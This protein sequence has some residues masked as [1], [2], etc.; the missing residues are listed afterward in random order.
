M[1]QKAATIPHTKLIIKIRLRTDGA[2]RESKEAFLQSGD[3]FEKNHHGGGK[4]EENAAQEVL[5]LEQRQ[6]EEK[7]PGSPHTRRGY[8]QAKVICGARLMPITLA[9]PSR[10]NSQM[11]KVVASEPTMPPVQ[12]ALIFLKNMVNPFGRWELA[13]A[14]AARSCRCDSVVVAVEVYHLLP[15]G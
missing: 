7:S 12:A 8:I 14:A 4:A 6:Q 2:E 5:L 13:A 10:P 3:E 1:Y 9:K 11:A 15:A